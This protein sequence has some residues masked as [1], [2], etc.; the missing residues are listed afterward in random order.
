MRRAP[1]P[2]SRRRGRP[3]C[4]RSPGGSAPRPDR[5]SARP[6]TLPLQASQRSCASSQARRC[7]QIARVEAEV[8]REALEEKPFLVDDVAGF[9]RRSLREQRANL[10]PGDLRL[11]AMA[12]ENSPRVG[13]FPP[14]VAHC[15]VAADHRG[16]AAPRPT[17]RRGQG[18]RARPAA[19]RRPDEGRRRR[20]PAPPPPRLQ[21][22]AGRR[23]RPRHTSARRR[24]SPRGA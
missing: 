10:R 6:R 13:H 14:E 1:A 2:R 4:R 9:G 12:G 8:G 22:D 3:R 7:R 15:R 5:P 23:A 11:A 24:A 20:D 19:A 18:S 21:A 17:A 16:S